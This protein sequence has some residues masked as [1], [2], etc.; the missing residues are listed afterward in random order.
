MNKPL[1]KRAAPPLAALALLIVLALPALLSGCEPNDWYRILAAPPP[2]ENLSYSAHA[3][4]NITFDFTLPDLSEELSFFPNYS[5]RV[6]YY[7]RE[8]MG[9]TETYVGR[10]Y[11]DR[12]D[13]GQDQHTA[14][15]ISGLTVATD[16]VF[17][18]YVVDTESQKSEPA[19]TL[20][21]TW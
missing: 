15:S 5:F 11:F 10:F 2:V 6:F 8:A 4:N 12:S 18:L 21:V 14:V 16:Y 19:E 7:Y 1:S 20:P 9:T 17:V 3:A 13:A